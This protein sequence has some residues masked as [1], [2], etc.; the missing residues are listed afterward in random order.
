MNVLILSQFFSTT[1]G[2]GEYLFNIITKKLDEHNHKV[3]VITNRIL[4]EKYENSENVKIIFVPPILEYKGGLPPS[5]LDNI[6]FVINAIIKGLKIIKNE[7]IELIHS[8][9]F[10]PALAGS[11]LSFF[12]SKPHI[13]SIWD[14]FTLCGKD[15]WSKWVK[16]K[17]VSKIHGIIGPRFEKLVLKIPCKAIHTISE[18]TN[19]DL[20][21]F[22][23]KKPIHV[24][25]PA[26]EK[27]EYKKI[28]QNPLQFIYIGRLVFYKN[29]E[30]L[31]K[32][33]N[34]ARKT[35]PKIKLVIVG[36]GPHESEI[37]NLINELKLESNI[38]LIGYVTTK[39]KFE[40][41]SQSNAMVFP[42]LCEGFG[43]VILEAFSQNK[44][45]LVSDIRPMSDIV[46]NNETGYVLDPHD[47][48]EWA[49]KMLELIQNPE[50]SINMGQIGME[51]LESRYSMQKM[52]E[53][54]IQMYKN[55]VK[56]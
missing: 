2:G 10:S 23:A 9:N 8:N 12:T 53:E 5:F 26:I 37:R 7:K 28:Q 14:I 56:S 21:K 32:A 47:E 49:R 27:I 19:D 6:R 1:K 11:I 16:Q 40:L 33:I 35:E 24:I 29:L 36:G 43:L 31:I 38:K 55:Y 22:G 20:V 39:E 52:Y 42:S 48:H 44:P 45:V 46:S 25:F 17:G 18:A 54:I 4:D 30:V 13:T 50:I 15:Y 41:L 51:Q 3:W 34:I